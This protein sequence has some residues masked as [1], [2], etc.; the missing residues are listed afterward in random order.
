[1]GICLTTGNLGKITTMGWR[2]VTIVIGII[3]AVATSMDGATFLLQS[4]KV[5]K[6]IPNNKKTQSITLLDLSRPKNTELTNS[7]SHNSI[8]QRF[9]NTMNP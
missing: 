4:H 2:R 3:G 6:K 8:V 5:V 1:M 7:Q 9:N